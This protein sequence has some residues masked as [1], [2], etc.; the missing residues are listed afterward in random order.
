MTA[1]RLLV[2]VTRALSVMSAVRA[3]VAASRHARQPG[4]MLDRADVF[5]LVATCAEAA[6]RHL[7]GE[8]QEL[9]R[10]LAPAARAAGYLIA[11]GFDPAYEITRALERHPSIRIARAEYFGAPE[12]Q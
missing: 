9:A 12:T 2:P 5:E 8:P 4:S 11:A 1:S 6:A 10:V 7:F 3:L